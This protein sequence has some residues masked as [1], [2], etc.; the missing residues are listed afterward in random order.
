VFAAMNV[1][2]TWYLHVA[3]PQ[4]GSKM[5]FLALINS[6]LSDMIHSIHDA[7]APPRKLKQQPNV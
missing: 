5:L 6:S 4:Q 3:P 1:N 2:G 7:S